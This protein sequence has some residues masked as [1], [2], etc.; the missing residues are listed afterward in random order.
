MIYFLDFRGKDRGGPVLPG[1]IVSLTGI[2]SG[3]EDALCFES[4]IIFLIHGFNVDR[5]SG[6]ANLRSLAQELVSAGDAALVAVTWPGD[7]WANALSYPLEGN[8]ADDEGTGALHRPRCQT[9]HVALLRV[10]QSRC[11]GGNGD[12]QAAT[13]R[14]VRDVSGLHDGRGDR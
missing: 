3:Q 11:T 10:P 13:A 5:R 12:D 7:N 14:S 9:G 6:Q 4:R 2:V 1:K 8:D